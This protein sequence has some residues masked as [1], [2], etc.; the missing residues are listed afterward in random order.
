MQK[1]YESMQRG[2]AVNHNPINVLV[3]NELLYKL[4]LITRDEHVARF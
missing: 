1:N 3:Q 4:C 2:F